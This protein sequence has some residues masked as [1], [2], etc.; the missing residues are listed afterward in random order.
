MKG[1]IRSQITAIFI[2]VIVCI[3]AGMF[4]INSGFLGRYYVVHKE[5]DLIETYEVIDGALSDGKFTS[6]NVQDKVLNQ[7]EKTNIDISIMDTAGGNIIFSTIKDERGLLFAR[8]LGYFFDKNQDEGMVLESTE[9]Y[10]ILKATDSKNKTD[11]LEMWGYFSDG[12]FFT[13]RSPLESIRESADL[14][15][16]FLIYIGMMGILLG[17]ILVWFFSKKITKPILELAELSRRMAKLDF[18]AKYTSGG[19]NEIRIL[20]ESFNSMSKRLEKT[21]SEL[22]RANNKLL[23]DIEQ[24]EKIEDMRKEFLGNVSHELKTPIALIQGYAEGL[25]EGVN[26]DPESREFYC[27]VIM[28]EAGKMNQMVKNLLTL[29]QLEFGDDDLEFER[30]DIVGLIRGVVASCEILIQQAQAQVSF[31]AESPVCVWADEFKTE[32]VVRNYLTNAIHHAENEKRIEIR[33]IPGKDTVRITV[34]NSGKPIP[35]EDLS[36]LWDK[37]YKVD[38]AH[39]R[40]YGGNGIG[41]SIVKA[42]MESFHQDYGVRNFDNGVEFWFELD[43]KCAADEEECRKRMSE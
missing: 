3:L 43:T 8:M 7:S 11:Y 35:E 6:A 24:K 14:A 30:F 4:V 15:N 42:I 23:K 26:D 18:D 9:D 36:K 28:D 37:F 20:G 31:V 13:M 12:S 2:G 1:S 17:G 29:N 10:Q 19:S 32:Q 5:K 33:V 40:E 16:T 34:F 41:L 27:D 39:T 25:K 22:K 21:V 38:K